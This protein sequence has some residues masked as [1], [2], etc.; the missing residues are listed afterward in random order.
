MLGQALNK[1][2]GESTARSNRGEEGMMIGASSG[3]LK[4]Q[5]KTNNGIWDD[6]DVTSALSKQIAYKL[7]MALGT[8]WNPTIEKLHRI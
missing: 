7:R 2:K 4:N 3:E 6:L 1:Q 8:T 5:F